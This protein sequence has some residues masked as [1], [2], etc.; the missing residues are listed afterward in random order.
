[1]LIVPFRSFKSGFGSLRHLASKGPQWE[2]SWFFLGIEPKN[3]ISSNSGRSRKLRK[4][5]PSIRDAKSSNV[6]VSEN[7][8]K[9]HFIK[10]LS[11]HDKLNV[12]RTRKKSEP[13]M[14]FDPRPSV[15]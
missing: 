8:I 15:I 12:W 3:T 6:N 10:Q 14:G 13:Q 11:K 5:G 7:R 2:L 4:R 1:M 9:E